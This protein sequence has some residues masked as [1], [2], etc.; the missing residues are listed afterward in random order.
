[1]EIVFSA[2]VFHVD[3]NYKGKTDSIIQKFEDWFAC[4]IVEFISKANIDGSY[5]KKSKLSL[6]SNR[7]SFLGENISSYTQLKIHIQIESLIYKEK[8]LF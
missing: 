1:M 2:V 6:D 4:I 3:N 5:L 8:H 7:S